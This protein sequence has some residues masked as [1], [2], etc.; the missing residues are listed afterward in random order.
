MSVCIVS[1][2]KIIIDDPFYFQITRAA[3]ARPSML[4]CILLVIRVSDIETAHAQ[5][6][7]KNW[8]PDQFRHLSAI[9]A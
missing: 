3:H 1:G 8:Q 9:C 4:L 7:A 2:I 5:D 6:S